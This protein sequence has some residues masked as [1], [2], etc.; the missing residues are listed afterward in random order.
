VRGPHRILVLHSES[1]NLPRSMI[2]DSAFRAA[3]AQDTVEIMVNYEYLDQSRYPDARVQSVQQTWLR[4]K[5]RGRGLEAV[6][7]I[8]ELAVSTMMNAQTSIAPGVP[9]IVW[10]VEPAGRPW[11]RPAAAITGLIV[12]HDVSGTI[13]DALTMFPGRRELVVIAGSARADS[14]LLREARAA[15]RPFEAQLP[16]RYLV[17]RSLSELRRE[18]AALTRTTLILF[19]NM[20]ADA[21]GNEYV[22][23]DVVRALAA[24]AQAPIFAL[25]STQLGTGIVGG[26][27]MDYREMAGQLAAL[28]LRVLRGESAAEISM[29]RQRV[30]RAVFDRRALRRW[31]VASSRLPSG[32]EQWFPSRAWLRYRGQFMAIIGLCL[33]EALLITGLL[34]QRRK[35]GR[36]ERLLADRLRF[37]TVLADTSRTF[38]DVTGDR[39]NIELQRWLGRI[40]VAAGA[41]VVALMRL[42]DNGTKLEAVH[43]WRSSRRLPAPVFALGRTE[44]DC[45]QRGMV[46]S[47]AIASAHGEP[48]TLVL[49]PLAVGGSSWGALVLETATASPFGEGVPTS[50]LRV[51]GEV[52]ANALERNRAVQELV[53]RTQS[54]KESHAEYRRLA[55]RLTEAQE[56]ERRRIARELH[57]DITQ[58]LTLIGLEAGEIGRTEGSTSAAPRPAIERLTEE[59]SALIGDVTRLSHRLHPSL[60]ERVGLPAA[61]R[62]LCRDLSGQ[63]GLEIAFSDRDIPGDLPEA[64]SLAAYRVAQEALRNAIKHSGARQ[65]TVD[66]RVEDEK[67]ALDIMDDGHGFDTGRM[68][69]DEGLGLLSMAERVQVLNGNLTVRSEPGAGT[70]VHME[71][72][73]ARADQDYLAPSEAPV[74]LRYPELPSD[75]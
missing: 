10:M 18:T 64:Q 54:L 11:S 31:D 9:L 42:D 70:Q 71:L 23:R 72:P 35:R 65:A 26:R 7:A 38:T 25:S 39:V 41:R 3:I 67:L 49:V 36:A 24:S 13:E 28:T 22:S 16:V 2:L 61:V 44:V 60:L 66:L 30:H 59:L 43:D 5:Y 20:R 48:G 6:V 45:I 57:D 14:L 8:G 55:D 21:A 69:D 50:R 56:N 63:Q 40:G 32:S 4:E 1:A 37:E 29:M 73:L 52:L 53:A 15:L 47:R 51:L 17:G 27:L 62:A 34:V 75:G 33:L 58:R 12:Q 19:L 68:G 46:I 74:R